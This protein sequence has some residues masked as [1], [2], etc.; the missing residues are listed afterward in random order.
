MHDIV[1]VEYR[2]QTLHG[3]RLVRLARLNVFPKDTLGVARRTVSWS[4]LFIKSSNST[5]QGFKI[6]K[7][8]WFRRAL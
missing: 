8:R 2:Y 4:G 6:R 5:E 1:L 3:S 7:A